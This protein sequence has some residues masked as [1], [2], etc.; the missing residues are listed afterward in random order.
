MTLCVRIMQ[1]TVSSILAHLDRMREH[2]AAQA[3]HIKENCAVQAERLRESYGARRGRFK[4]YRSHQAERIRDNYT[5]QVLS[6]F[7]C[8]LYGPPHY[9]VIMDQF[10]LSSLSSQ[11][12][13]NN[14]VYDVY[15]CY[16]RPPHS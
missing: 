12:V 13:D 11:I 2:Y 8:F 5:A 3:A 14:N 7:L 16:S 9:T 15:V 6:F 10:R 4:N 1:A